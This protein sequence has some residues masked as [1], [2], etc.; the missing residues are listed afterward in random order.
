MRSIFTADQLA[1][2]EVDPD[3]P[4]ALVQRVE[5]ELQDLAL[6][7]AVVGDVTRVWRVE[8]VRDQRQAFGQGPLNDRREAWRILTHPLLEHLDAEVYVARLVAR[9]GDEAA[10]EAAVRGA[11]L[12][13]P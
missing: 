11:P 13:Q 10:I 3:R 2:G 4:Q 5:R 7:V 12:P 1:G 8:R 6:G 9:H